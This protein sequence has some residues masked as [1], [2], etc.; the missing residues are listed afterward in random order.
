MKRL[1][2]LASFFAVL[3]LIYASAQTASAC[4]CLRSGTVD[5]EFNRTPNIVILKLKSVEKFAESEQNYAVGGIRQS[6]LTVEKVFKGNLKVGQEMTFAQGGGGDCIW[7]F[8]EGAVGQEYLFYL[9]EK[10]VADKNPDGII[11]STSSDNRTI[12]QEVWIAGTCSRSGSAAMR[13]GDIK[14]LENAAKLRGKTRLSGALMQ[15]FPSPTEEPAA[16]LKFLAG[17]K[18]TIRGNGKAVEL[19]T[20]ENGLYEIYDLPAGKYTVTPERIIGYKHSYG[21]RRDS[22][23]VEIKPRAHAEQDFNYSIDNRLGG[24]LFDLNGKP[25]ESV[26]LKLIPASGTLSKYFYKADCTDEKGRFEIAEIPPG[27]YVLMSNNDGEITAEEP[28]ETFYYPNALKREDAVEITIGAGDFRDDLILTAP[29]SAELVTISGVL[30][31]EDGK[32]AVIE[33]AGFISVKFVEEGEETKPERERVIASRTRVD[34]KGRF[35]LR[36]LKGRKGIIYASSMSLPGVY[37][38]CPKYDKLMA[39]DGGFTEIESSSERIEATSD[40]S[41]IELKLPF[42]GCQKAKTE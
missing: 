26:C 15:S 24:R 22:V 4:S 2:I 23:E 31:Y 21:E 11:A 29:K 40:L 37:L 10:P 18:V 34:G 16:R 25:V 36:V 33:N 28:F 9:G 19:K 30:L 20:D 1:H 38:N 39:E 13:S 5:E 27:T 3:M 32:P 41:G 12:K 35:T 8:D 6:K 14:Y 42:P 7:T 17:Y